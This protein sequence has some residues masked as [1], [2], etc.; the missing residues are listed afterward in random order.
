M[1]FDAL[2]IGL[3]A[4]LAAGACVPAG[5]AVLDFTEAER[6]AILRH[7]PWPR[8]FERDSSNRLSGNRAA[9]AFGRMLFFDPRLSTHGQQSCAS[10]HDP[11][12]AWTDGR[13][14]AAGH[15]DIRRNTISVLNA[16][17]NRWF[18]WSGASDSLWAASLR[19]L[20]DAREMGAAERHVVTL[21]RSQ[22]DLSRAY[23]AAIGRGPPADGDAVLA[24]VG[25][26]LAAFQE[27]LVT[28]RT[29][30]DAFRDAVARGDRNAM[31]R[32]PVAAQRGVK[33][34]VGKAQCNLCHFGATFSNGE[35]DKV[36]IPVRNEAG[37]FDWGR[38]DGIKAVLASRYN[39]LS[40]HSD[41]A[42]G[43]TSTRH[44][45]LTSEAYG[46]FR[47]PGLRNVALT[48]PYM[49][50]GRLATLHDVVRHYSEITPEK[51]HIAA[52]HPHA[53]PGEPMPPRPAES[54]LRTLALS[55]REV[56]DVVA[57]LETLTEHRSESR[58]PHGTSNTETRR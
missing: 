44:V 36:G 30:F 52:S 9:V 28:G 45:A 33:L 17:F 35:F 7:G 16:R 27:T 2:V 55:A 12:R 53:E 24:D 10:C 34:F 37:D 42:D 39:R 11:A 6:V 54:P 57:F 23:K 58:A 51:L 41:D 18:G 1:R 22:D 29:A 43:A 50:N 46:A 25:K 4:V 20:M 5:A 15:E 47:V 3:P 19:P 8:P 38:Y 21:V 40:R 31:A 14:T 32:Y 56:D 49:H 26:A 48:A 13:T